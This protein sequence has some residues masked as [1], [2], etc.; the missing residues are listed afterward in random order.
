MDFLEDNETADPATWEDW[1][2]IVGEN[3]TLT[4]LQAFKAMIKYL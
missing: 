2:N 3:Q 1:I 4:T